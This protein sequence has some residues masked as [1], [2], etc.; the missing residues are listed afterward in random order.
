M[1]HYRPGPPVPPEGW[2]FC[3]ADYDNLHGWT[4]V[5]VSVC[6][7]VAAG[8]ESFARA[9]ALVMEAAPPAAYRIVRDVLILSDAAALMGLYGVSVGVPPGRALGIPD[10]PPVCSDV[11]CPS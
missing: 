8:P 10:P 6:A 4:H 3:S 9:E 7:V 1:T 11:E 2:T 5:G